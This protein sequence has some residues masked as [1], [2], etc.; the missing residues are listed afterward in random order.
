MSNID[1][2]ISVIVNACNDKIGFDIKVLD[3]RK[4]TTITDYFVIVSG[5]STSQVAAIA[6]E[7][8]KKMEESNYDILGKEGYKEARWVLLS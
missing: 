8:E 1:K 7:I 5:N 2:S 4:L 6:E 3:L